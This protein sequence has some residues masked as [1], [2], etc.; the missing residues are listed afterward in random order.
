MIRNLKALGLMV[1]AALAISAM[2]V[3]AAQATEGNGFYTCGKTATPNVHTTCNVHGEQ[4]GTVAENFFE[5]GGQKVTCENAG[6]T[7]TAHMPTG[8]STHLTV[9]PH[10]KDCSAEGLP[11][12]VSMNGC[13]YTFRRPTTSGKTHPWDATVDLVCPAGKSVDIEVFLFGTPTGSHTVNACTVKVLPKNGL[14]NSEASVNTTG[15]KDDLTLT[16][17]ITNVKYERTGSCGASSGEN[18]KYVSKVTVTA[19]GAAGEA[20]DLWLSD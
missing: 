2:F 18:A 19:K 14:T 4:Y 5:A 11:A 8:T 7:F 17:N 15:A 3:S 13:T 12:T 9:T 20:E 1:V 6:V 10:Y 16:A